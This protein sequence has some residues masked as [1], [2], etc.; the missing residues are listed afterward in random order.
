MECFFERWPLPWLGLDRLASISGC[1]GRREEGIGSIYIHSKREREEDVQLQANVKDDFRVWE[2]LR[3]KKSKMKRNPHSNT[4]RERQFLCGI[5][6]IGPISPF[7]FVFTLASLRCAKDP[8]H[9]PR[10][11]LFPSSPLPE[12]SSFGA[13]LSLS[14]PRRPGNLWAARDASSG[15][16]R[17][18]SLSTD[19]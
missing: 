13:H 1:E 6:S 12:S 3:G 8:F 19:L 5:S 9:S 7:L 4:W 14:R 18:Y 16:S 15:F 2:I 11:R 10:V 17:K